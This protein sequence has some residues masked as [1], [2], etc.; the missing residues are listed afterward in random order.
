METTTT[1]GGRHEAAP[2][3]QPARID[4]DVLDQPPTAL[5]AWDDAT[6]D[7]DEL[8]PTVIRGQE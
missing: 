5:A 1:T 6:N 3:P 2:Q 7:A 4:P 8:G